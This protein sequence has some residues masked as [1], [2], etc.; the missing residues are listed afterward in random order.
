MGVDWTDISQDRVK[1]LAV[2]NTV[3]SIRVWLPKNVENFLSSWETFRFSRSLLHSVNKSHL[4]KIYNC[5]ATFRSACNTSSTINFTTLRLILIGP[6][7]F[8][9]VRCCFC[10]NNWY[11]K[12]LFNVPSSIL[13][14]TQVAKEDKMRK[15]PKIRKNAWKKIFV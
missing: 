12:F 14:V 11:L 4:R 3:I 9:F 7:K 10:L 13:L 5:I 1:E 15:T 2:L 6:F 8:K